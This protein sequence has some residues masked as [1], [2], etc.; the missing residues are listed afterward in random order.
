M[1]MAKVIKCAASEHGSDKGNCIC[2]LIG[3]TVSLEPGREIEVYD[4]KFILYH[5]ADSD[6]IVQADEL[7]ILNAA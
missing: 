7:L 3:Q 5:I 1:Q 6:K 2:D 4:H